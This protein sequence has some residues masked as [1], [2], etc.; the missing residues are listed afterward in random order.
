MQYNPHIYNGQQN[1]NIA[2]AP[3]L[4]DDFA[5]NPHQLP[6][7]YPNHMHVQQLHPLHLYP[8]V[9]CNVH[10][11]TPVEQYNREMEMRK[12]QE[13]ECCCI[14]LLTILCCCLY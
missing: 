3:P 1:L 6:P 2:T 4:D 9:P 13:D 11:T 10:C 14:G 5:T 12:K 8:D 7:N